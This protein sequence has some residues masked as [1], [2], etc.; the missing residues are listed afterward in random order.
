M[1]ALEEHVAVGEQSSVCLYFMQTLV[2]RIHQKC[3]VDV[4]QEV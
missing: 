3:V 4:R 1:V 2:K